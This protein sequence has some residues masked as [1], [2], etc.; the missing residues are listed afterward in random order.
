MVFTWAPPRGGNPATLHVYLGP[1]ISVANFRAIGCTTL[2]GALRPAAVLLCPLPPI[3]QASG[4][5]V[6]YKAS[7]LLLAAPLIVSCVT[8]STLLAESDA[9]YE[10]Y[11]E[12]WVSARECSTSD[13]CSIIQGH[14]ITGH[15]L[16][17]VR[18]D[19]L[20]KL[21]SAERAYYDAARRALERT[22]R[23]SSFTI[24]ANPT[25][26][27][28]QDGAPKCIDGVCTLGYLPYN[29]EPSEGRVRIGVASGGSPENPMIC[30][31]PQTAARNPQHI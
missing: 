3:N 9:A 30:L 4:L 31:G 6:M 13:Q 15:C 22:D 18:K 21:L 1:Q 17:T 14:C 5:Y 20:A 23:D 25:T 28:E 8:L 11:W 29:A 2:P 12:T 19:G 24:C 27:P 7:L 16:D 10:R 26:C